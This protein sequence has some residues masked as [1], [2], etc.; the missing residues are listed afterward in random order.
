MTSMD[1][2]ENFS[3]SWGAFFMDSIELGHISI[4]PLSTI[5]QVFRPADA[6][7]MAIEPITGLG[8]PDFPW[9]TVPPGEWDEVVT[10]VLM[11]PR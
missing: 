4:Q 10:N 5:T 11:M 3:N 6:P 2:I 8:H 1:K 9:R 7:F